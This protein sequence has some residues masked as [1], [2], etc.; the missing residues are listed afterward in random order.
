V[1]INGQNYGLSTPDA[2]VATIK[3]IVG[4]V[5]GIDAHPTSPTQP[6]QLRLVRSPRNTTA[7]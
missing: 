3:E 7:K 2:L 4:P 1:R 6:S 5:P